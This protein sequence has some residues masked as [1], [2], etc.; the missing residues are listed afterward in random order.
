MTWVDLHAGQRSLIAEGC[1]AI[2][3]AT[4]AAGWQVPSHV[5]ETARN[6]RER[7][8]LSSPVRCRG[9]ELGGI[10]VARLGEQL[11]NRCTLHDMSGM[12]DDDALAVLRKPGLNH[13]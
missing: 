6:R 9:N 1:V 8:E 7:I 2:T 11:P 10:G 4:I 3:A 5:G 13:G 12:H